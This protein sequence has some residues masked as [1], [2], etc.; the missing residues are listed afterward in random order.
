MQGK[1]WASTLSCI[2]PEITVRK[3]ILCSVQKAFLPEFLVLQ[4]IKSSDVELSGTEEQVCSGVVPLLRLLI[5][6][7]GKENYQREN[8]DLLPGILIIVT[9]SLNTV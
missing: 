1:C 7:L 8:K 5:P 4:L 6:P 9:L 2:V 3:E